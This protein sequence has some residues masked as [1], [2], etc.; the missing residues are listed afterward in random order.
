MVCLRYES[1][2]FK[3]CPS[4]YLFQK[5]FKKVCEMIRKRYDLRGKSYYGLCEFVCIAEL[6]IQKIMGG[7]T[8]R[9]L[10]ENLEGLMGFI[11]S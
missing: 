4:I 11:S 3:S 1:Q 5:K 8:E 9:I 10:I 2:D 7:V 6:E